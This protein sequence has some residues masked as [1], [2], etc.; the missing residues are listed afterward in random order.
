VRRLQAL[1]PFVGVGRFV[2]VMSIDFE[3]RHEQAA[4]VVLILDDQNSCRAGVSGRIRV[5]GSTVFG[6]CHG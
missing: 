3:R 4:D 5:S 2:D 6:A 1:Q